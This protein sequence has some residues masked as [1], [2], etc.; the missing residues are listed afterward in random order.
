MGT[1]RR[2]T[3]G[4][5]EETHRAGYLLQALC[6]GQLLPRLAGDSP[7]RLRVSDKRSDFETLAN[8]IRDDGLDGTFTLTDVVAPS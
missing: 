4:E 1:G 7:Y 6:A 8:Q 5:N 2:G 3:R